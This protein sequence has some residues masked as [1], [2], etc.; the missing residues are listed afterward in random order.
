MGIF[1]HGIEIF[2]V[3]TMGVIFLSFL[4]ARNTNAPVW[5]QDL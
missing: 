3:I 2:I 5:Q 4:V 1:T